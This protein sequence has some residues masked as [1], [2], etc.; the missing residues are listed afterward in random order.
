MA[1]QMAIFVMYFLVLLGSG[2]IAS[3]LT[4][5]TEDFYIAGGNIGWA[6]G[7]ATIAATQ[8]SSGLY[9]GTIGMM[10]KVGWSFAWVA[11]VFPVAYWAMTAVVAPRFTRVKKLS[12]PDFIASRYYSNTAR[13]IASIIIVVSFVVYIQAQIVAG[14]L[15]ANII[16]GF[17]QVTGMILFTAILLVYTVLGG[18]LAVIYNDFINMMI[19]LAGSFIA[20][21]IAIHYAGGFD[22]LI[23]Y[24]VAAN[25]IT[26][27]WQGMPP[28]LL[29]SIA[30]AFFLGA[31]GRPEQLVRFYAMKDMPTIRR[32][33]AFTIFLVGAAHLLV[34]I[35]ALSS[36]AFFPALPTGD[37][38]MPLIA[39]A[40]LPPAIGALILASVAAAMMSTV[41]SL[42]MV[43][44]TALSHDIYTMLINPKAT[45]KQ[46]M[47]VARL[48]VV[49]VGVLPL[50][51]LL[52]GVGGGD[53][54]Q[55]IVALF[56]ALMGAGFTLPVVLGILWPRANKEGAIASMVGG[57]ATAFL[58]RAFGN[59]AL[60]DPVVPGF[61]VALVLM[62]GVSL[63]TPA[64]PREAIEP[65]FSDSS[66]T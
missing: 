66:L 24:A 23:N 17:P 32:G 64:P 48:G 14:G 28:S 53:L 36:S 37:M 15:I 6:L 40:V 62:V 60:L 29:F 4:K 11:L 61:L 13:A 20:V 42:L 31:F 46:K 35:L 2:Y 1:V 49:A 12:L 39:R 3:K 30:L 56:S 57:I 43:A 45:E 38:A 19:M 34:F 41:D 51:L 25:P 27:T 44:G 33:I 8:M 16:F 18:M 50:V 54:V 65:F 55:M 9:I 10:Y 26:F 52:S 5:G 21:P 63:M 22:N 59:T 47:W 7:G 58:W